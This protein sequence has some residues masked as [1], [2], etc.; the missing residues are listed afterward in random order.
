MKLLK[1][2]ACFHFTTCVSNYGEQLKC[3]STGLFSFFRTFRSGEQNR[4]VLFSL[5]CVRSTRRTLIGKQL[6]GG[7]IAKCCLPTAVPTAWHLTERAAACPTLVHHKYTYYI[8]M[9]LDKRHFRIH[10]ITCRASWPTGVAALLLCCRPQCAA[11]IYFLANA[12]PHTHTDDR[13]P[14]SRSRFSFTFFISGIRNF[15]CKFG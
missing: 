5:L 1:K 10:K 8:R 9:V 11:V 15:S 13:T 12:D 6:V 14:G 7:R 2:L 4:G 3:S